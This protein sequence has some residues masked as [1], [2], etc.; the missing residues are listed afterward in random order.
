MFDERDYELA[1]ALTERMLTHSLQQHHQRTRPAGE[2]VADGVC[3]DCGR[4]IAAARLAV[5]P[6]ASRCVRCQENHEWTMTVG[7]GF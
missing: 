5:M 2:G 1:S 6:Y 7:G 4:Q 3:V